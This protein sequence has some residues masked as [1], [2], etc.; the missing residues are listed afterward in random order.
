L[1]L[2]EAVDA[3]L[4]VDDALL[5]AE[6]GMTDGTD[7][8]F[9]LFLRRAGDEGVAAEAMDYGVVIV[10]RVNSCFHGHLI[11]STIRCQDL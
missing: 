2:L 7:L 11:V 6:E 4:G 10:G 8:G 9:E 5:A 3:A 1:A